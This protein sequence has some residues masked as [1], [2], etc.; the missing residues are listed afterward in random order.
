MLPCNFLYS[1]LYLFQKGLPFATFSVTLVKIPSERAVPLARVRMDQREPFSRSPIVDLAHSCY[2]AWQAR[3]LCSR[4]LVRG[5]G[6][7]MASSH[8]FNASSLVRSLL[9]IFVF[10]GLR[11]VVWR[12]HVEQGDET[13]VR[14][15]G[16]DAPDWDAKQ[17]LDG[18]DQH[19]LV[20]AEDTRK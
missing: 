15:F 1:S 16:P 3:T 19:G 2:N 5:W 12:H 9:L 14:L 20:A 8:A 18:I 4:L 11:L 13:P 17:G 10:L 6:T 7:N